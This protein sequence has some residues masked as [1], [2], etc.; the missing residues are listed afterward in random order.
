MKKNRLFLTVALAGLVSFTSCNNNSKTEDP[1]AE[2]TPEIVEEVVGDKKDNH[3]CL[4]SAGETW[5]EL[6]QD[7][8]RI[9]EV[10]KRLNPIQNETQNQEEAVFSAF[11]L[12]DSDENRAE[13]F[14]PESE[15]STFILNKSDTSEEGI[16][17]NAE[18]KYDSEHAI[19]YIDGKEKYRAENSSE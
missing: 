3:G 2:D 7:C 14:L 11:V 10:A 9:F 18:Y 17:K 6:K 8:I 13:L 4:V 19:L 12:V 5:S 1:E 16:Y 15:K